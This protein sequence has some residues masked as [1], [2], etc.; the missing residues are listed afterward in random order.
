[1]LPDGHS[2]EG[3]AR[4]HRAMMRATAER[5]VGAAGAEDIVQKALLR[6]WI[7][8][9]HDEVVLR[10]GAWLRRITQ[11][12]A[13]NALTAA[14]RRSEVHVPEAALGSGATDPAG[15]VERADTL[16]RALAVLAAL[17]PAVRASFV[18]CA[19]QGRRVR[20]VALERGLAEVTVRNQVHLARRAIREA[21]R[22]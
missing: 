6:A 2:F 5:Y 8:L 17:T 16:R 22:E 21:D 18:S 20:E 19:V 4:R 14:R 7:A 15:I 13:L 11:R 10:E 12:E 1:M 9:E 3:M